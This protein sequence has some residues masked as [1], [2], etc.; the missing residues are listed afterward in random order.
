M[1]ENQELAIRYGI[2][3]IPALLFFPSGS[4]ELAH[5]IVGVEREEKIAEHLN[6]LIG[7]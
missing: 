1:D 5:K 2:Q 3:A 4:D 6:G 7:G